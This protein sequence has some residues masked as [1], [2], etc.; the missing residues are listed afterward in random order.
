MKP[1][2]ILESKVR[3]IA[4]GHP[5][6]CAET[7]HFCETAFLSEALN[8]MICALHYREA[9]AGDR[10]RR[11]LE[12]AAE[13]SLR[14][15][16]IMDASRRICEES[17]EIF[18]VGRVGI[19]LFDEECT[20]LRCLNEY[21]GA[22]HTYT[23]GRMISRSGCEPYF[24]ALEQEQL[25]AAEDVFQDLRT[26]CLGE[27]YLRSRKTASMLCA[28]ICGGGR[29][30]GVICF[31]Q[32]NRV[33][34]WVR[35]EV[36]FA[37]T[38]ARL[39]DAAL[40][41]RD[42]RA[43]RADLL[44]AREEA[45]SASQSKSR[46]LA[47]MSHEIRTP[48]NGVIGMLKLLRR[49]SLDM[50]QRRCVQQGLRSSKILLGVINDIL[51]FSKIEAGMLEIEQIPFN[52]RN[53]AYDAIQLFTHQAEEKKLQMSCVVQRNV[54]SI[55]RGDP[56][57]ISQVLVNLI[58]NAVK[59]TQAHGEVVVQVRLEDENVV[60]S[61]VRFEVRDTGKGISSDEL[62][63][64]F[65]PFRQ[66]E[67]STSR[68]YGGTG[69]GLGICRQLVTLMGGNI[70]VESRLGRGTKFWFDLPLSKCLSDE[71]IDLEL[72]NIDGFHSTNARMRNDHDP[73]ASVFTNALFPAKTGETSPVRIL[74]AE[75]NE[76]NQMVG[77]EFLKMSGYSCDLAST[78]QEAI[79]AVLTQEYDLVFMDCMM[80]EMNGY[81]ATRRIRE[82][83]PEGRQVPIV[84]LTANAMKGD[85]EECLAAGMNDYL[86]KP[87]DPA[88]MMSMIMKWCP[89][90]GGSD[91]NGAHKS[92][93]GRR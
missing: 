72:K 69:L 71:A 30:R 64:I 74:L 23:Q 70:K 22:D 2:L 84:A 17:A 37:K 57:R 89:T 3:T 65:E 93:I 5:E 51:D 27:P 38:I 28:G 43:S 16:D 29:M 83:E 1:I 61:N 12:L 80:P 8:D 76:I 6:P 41:A 85:R 58:G 53:I 32:M 73:S 19:W 25:I 79:H 45:M 47:N 63:R 11:V 40:E 55:V 82:N 87:F 90:V 48:L 36:E 26:D 15:G 75:D 88:Q 56:A 7:T 77:A 18:G 4:E 13:A 59:F 39:T 10:G 86:C 46:F 44:R 24:E 66:E 91:L 60:S 54:P 35:D 49:G 81:E 42:Q 14:S 52:L 50:Q 34:S 21:N 68:C 20:E 31:E 33:R 62:D 92:S 67:R 9:L 78:G